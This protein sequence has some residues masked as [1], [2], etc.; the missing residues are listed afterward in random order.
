MLSELMEPPVE[1][2]LRELV[3]IVTALAETKRDCNFQCCSAGND[4]AVAARH[5][6]KKLMPLQA[7]QNKQGTNK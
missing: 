2:L 5:S 6:C 1:Q 7:D 3:T 4:T